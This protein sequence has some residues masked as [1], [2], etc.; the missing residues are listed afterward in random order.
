MF[1]WFQLIIW[2]YVCSRFSMN[3][4]KY[5][6]FLF[7]SLILSIDGISGQFWNTSSSESHP[8]LGALVLPMGQVKFVSSVL[9]VHLH[10]QVD[11]YIETQL[12]EVYK[13]T[14][15][16]LQLIKVGG[17]YL[18][19]PQKSAVEALIKSISYDF[20]DVLDFLTEK[21]VR[22][23]LN[24]VSVE[25]LEREWRHFCYEAINRINI[26]NLQRHV[27]PVIPR[28]EIS[29]ETTTTST[30]RP[31]PTVQNDQAWGNYASITRAHPKFKRGRSK[32]GLVDVGGSSS[33]VF[34]VSTEE[35]LSEVRHE[36]ESY[37]GKVMKSTKLIQ[38]QTKQAEARMADALSH[39]KSATESLMTVQ[40]RESRLETF[41]QISIILE[42]LESVVLHLNVWNVWY[43]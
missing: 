5:L 34:G 4:H 12:K 6:P 13:H 33:A 10:L 38:I 23:H 31:K 2:I 3:D 43:I 18:S 19:A 35:E 42:H 28:H 30:L 26:G 20:G 8:T 40:V 21:F 15:N 16:I 32:R 39:I 22:T 24:F 1:W 14:E 9:H 17:I 29:I 25:Q 11:S 27:A 41:T 36:F 37:I 7:L